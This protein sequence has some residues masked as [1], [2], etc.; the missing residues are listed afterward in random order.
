VAQLKSLADKEQAFIDAVGRRVQTDYVNDIG[1]SGFG[2]KSLRKAVSHSFKV[3]RAAPKKQLAFMKASVTNPRAAL[4]M[5]VATHKK[6]AR[7]SVKVGRQ[8]APVVAAAAAIYFGGPALYGALT[9]AASGGVGGALSLAAKGVSALSTVQKLAM[10]KKMDSLAQQYPQEA[11]ALKNQP[12]EVVL[13]SPLVQRAAQEL[14]QDQ[15][16]N[17]TGVMMESPMAMD[18][19][20]AQTADAAQEM[21]TDVA[22]PKKT[23]GAAT[24]A[25]IG[26]PILLSLLR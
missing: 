13:Q 20:G 26:L 17:N 1:L 25:V 5:A 8:V 4:N 23:G 11:A 7:E 2:L 16:Y 15:I 10:K 19:V 22:A 12:P 6:V 21:A 18:L 24:A 3:I 14:A 9:S